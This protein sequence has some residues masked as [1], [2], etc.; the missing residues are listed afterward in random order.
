MLLRH[1]EKY[2][3]RPTLLIMRDHRACMPINLIRDQG[4]PT[5][6]TEAAAE[7]HLDLTRPPV[8][9]PEG[10]HGLMPQE[11]GTVPEVLIQKVG[12]GLTGS[13]PLCG[14][15]E[16]A[17]ASSA[18]QR[19]DQQHDPPTVGKLGRIE[20]PLHLPEELLA[21]LGDL[22]YLGRQS[23]PRGRCIVC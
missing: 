7:D 3:N 13:T 19:G 9:F 21:H 2:L 22:G 18:S 6:F 11:V 15:G 16:A 23:V 4:H 1:F 8:Q 10:L 5:A 20:H 17:Q 12:H 14:C